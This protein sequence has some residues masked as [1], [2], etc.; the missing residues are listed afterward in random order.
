MVYFCVSSIEDY[1]E[2]LKSKISWKVDSLPCVNPL[3]THVILNRKRSADG[4]IEIF[5]A[6]IF[7]VGNC[8]V[9]E[10]RYN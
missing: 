1:Y 4:E 6:R 9:Y 10:E 5:R 7:L 8:Q 3:P 2:A